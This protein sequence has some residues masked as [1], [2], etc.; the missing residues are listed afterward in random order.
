MKKSRR[1]SD[2]VWYDTHYYTERYNGRTQWYD[3]LMYELQK[4]L[5]PTDRLLELGCGQ[6]TALIECAR[7]RLIP[8]SHIYGID[9]SKAAIAN[10]KKQLPTAHLRVGDIYSIP[11]KDHFFN[12]VTIME[13][14][15]HVENPQAVFTEIARVLKPTGTVYLSFPNFSV[16]PWNIVRKFSDMFSL[17]GIINKQPIDTI[18]TIDEIKSMA[19]KVGLECM[20]VTGVTYLTALLTPLESA[21]GYFA[22]RLLNRMGMAHRSLHPLLTFRTSEVQSR[23]SQ[24]STKNLQ[25]YQY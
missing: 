25:G 5:N 17:P 11:F 15:E 4:R 23:S 21:G 8:A 19:Q 9:Q 7:K 2:A 6:S 22:T 12:V 16:F 18:Y 20:S 24:R 14:I 13:V 1:L 10:L 3:M